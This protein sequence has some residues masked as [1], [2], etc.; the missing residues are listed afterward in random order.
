MTIDQIEELIRTK[1]GGAWWALFKQTA[2]GHKFW[3]TG[4]TLTN[5]AYD[6]IRRRFTS[7]STRKEV[8]TPEERRRNA[9]RNKAHAAEGGRYGR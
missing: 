9:I 5:A 2:T 7:L 8:V 4:H 1:H 3:P 6:E